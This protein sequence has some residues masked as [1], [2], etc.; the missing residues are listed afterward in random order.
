MNVN[1]EYYKIFYYVAK[2]GRITFAAKE[3]C[4]SQPAV[5]QAVK[6][7]EKE[8]GMELFIRTPKGVVLTQAGE[9]LYSYISSGYETILLGEK[10]MKELTNLEYGEVRIGASD[11]TL[12]FYLLPFLEKFHQQYPGIKVNVT[13]APTPRTIEHLYAGRIDFGVVTTPL[14]I[15]DRLHATKA[16]DVQDIFISGSRFTEY[17]SKI[18]NYRDLESMPL[19]CLENKTSTRVYVDNFLKEQGVYLAPEFELATSDMIVQ[20]VKRNLGIGSV[21]ADFAEK[22]MACGEIFKLEFEKE[23]PKRSMYVISDK[24]ISMSMAAVKLLELIR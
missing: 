14:P 13:N 24:K 2:Y 21:M 1:L 19:I 8:I 4:I 3:L 22:Y 6:Q 20:F 16:R 11:M 15:D 7:L 17:K 10:K 18:I 23:I 5:S 9:T 12:E